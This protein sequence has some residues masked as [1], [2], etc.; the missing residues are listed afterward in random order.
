MAGDATADH[1]LAVEKAENGNAQITA[2]HKGE[3]V[4]VASDDNGNTNSGM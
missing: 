2:K 1:L 4:V 3:M